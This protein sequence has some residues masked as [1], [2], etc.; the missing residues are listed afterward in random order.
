MAI[1]FPGYLVIYNIA[2]RGNHYCF[3]DLF[4]IAGI[5]RP[6][7]F[8]VFGTFTPV[9]QAGDSDGWVYCP[10][11]NGDHALCGM[12][13]AGDNSR[14]HACFT[15]QMKAWAKGRSLTLGVL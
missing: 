1:T 6:S 10:D 7:Y 12:L 11:P 15:D 2:Y 4:E 13:L 8:G 3:K 14:G 9:P 5:S